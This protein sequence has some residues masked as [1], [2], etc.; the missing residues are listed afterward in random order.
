MHYYYY[1]YY[2]Y[3]C[4]CYFTARRL[5]VVRRALTLKALRFAYLV[6]VRW[7]SACSQELR[8][9]YWEYLGEIR[10]WLLKQLAVE[11]ARHCNDAFTTVLFILRLLRSKM[12][13]YFSAKFYRGVYEHF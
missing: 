1:Y 8:L 2:Y 9:Y 11:N 10:D 6:V 3:Y 12:I 5:L 13:H 7:Q 4:C